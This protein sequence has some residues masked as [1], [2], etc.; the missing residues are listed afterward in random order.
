MEVKS[1]ELVPSSAFPSNHTV[2]YFF[3]DSVPEIN[4]GLEA[5]LLGAFGESLVRSGQGDLVSRLRGNFL[6][7]QRLKGG[8]CLVAFRC[9]R[10][11]IIDG[12]PL[13]SILVDVDARRNVITA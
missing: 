9:C 8:N 13:S 2:I 5:Q 3:F 11:L 4:E 7:T 6:R 12:M 1:Y 10:S